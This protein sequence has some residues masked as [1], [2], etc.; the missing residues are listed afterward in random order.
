MNASQRTDQHHYWTMEIPE[1]DIV[2]NQ[3]RND[4]SLGYPR[5]FARPQGQSRQGNPTIHPTTKGQCS[6]ICP[7]HPSLQDLFHNRHQTCSSSW[8][9]IHV[10]NVRHNLERRLQVAQEKNNDQ[11]V[12]L[13]RQ[14]YDELTV[15]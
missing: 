10:E 15:S 8:T 9:A 13:L 11:L 12:R 3:E 2:G 7:I 5:H 4:L 1:Q 14:E 6:T